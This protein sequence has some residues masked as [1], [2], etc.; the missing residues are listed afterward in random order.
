MLLIIIYKGYITKD[1]GQPHYRV[2]THNISSEE[3]TNGRREHQAL[4]LNFEEN[5]MIIT[6][7]NLFQ[8]CFR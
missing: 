6:N 1:F 4:T 2:R 5:K 7:K 8:V 3:L